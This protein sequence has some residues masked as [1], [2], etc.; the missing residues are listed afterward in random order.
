MEKTLVHRKTYRYEV[1]NNDKSNTVVLYVLHGYGQLVKYFI[2]KFSSLSDNLI[3]VAPEGMHRFYK[4]GNYG[5]V[6]ASW[7]TKEIREVDIQDNI[8]WLDALDTAISD[9]YNIKYR[10]VLGFSQ[11]GST[12]VRWNIQGKTDFS[13]MIIWASDFPPELKSMTAGL[14]GQELYF[15]VG[16]EDEF[17]NEEGQKELIDFYKKSG[18]KI[19]N[20]LGPHDIDKQ[21]LELVVDELVSKIVN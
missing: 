17:Y 15:C 19:S 12:A 10:F 1:L 4:K 5:R 18:F 8:E 3:I 13:G 20:Y 7:M 2:R 9:E 6:G 21:T 16:T 14:Y 11:G